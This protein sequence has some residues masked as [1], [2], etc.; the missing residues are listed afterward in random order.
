MSGQN[1]HVT[2]SAL[3][4][5]FGSS[6]SRDAHAATQ[7]LRHCA[8]P[9]GKPHLIVHDSLSQMPER[10]KPFLVRHTVTRRVPV[11][12]KPLATWESSPL[13]APKVSSSA[14]APK[15]TSCCLHDGAN[16]QRNKTS[17]KLTAQ[18]RTRL[19]A[20]IHP[21]GKARLNAN[22][23]ARKADRDSRGRS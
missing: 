20:R 1:R 21:W 16:S 14:L 4:V 15:K 18:R 6:Q 12:V 7:Q 19:P 8:S 10:E 9:F 2:P 23:A 3:V 22:A 11:R 5:A 17:K 13:A